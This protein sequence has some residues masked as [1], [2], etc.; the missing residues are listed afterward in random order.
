MTGRTGTVAQ[1]MQKQSKKALRK[2]QAAAALAGLVLVIAG[3]AALMPKGKGPDPKDL[4]EIEN[5]ITDALRAFDAKKYKEADDIC[6]KL[7]PKIKAVGTVEK[8]EFKEAVRKITAYHQSEIHPTA[9]AEGDAERAFSTWLPKVD[10]FLKTP[11]P[12]DKAEGIR[13]FDLGEP[14]HAKYPRYSRADEITKKLEELEKY[15]LD[16][17]GGD[18][19]TKVYQSIAA[20]IRKMLKDKMFGAAVERWKTGK[21]D[22]KITDAKIKGQID[23]QVAKVLEQAKLQLDKWTREA[24][25]KRDDLS[26]RAGGLKVL[27]EARARIKGLADLEKDLEERIK[28]YNEGKKFGG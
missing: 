2:F 23:D 20:E 7:E 5:L 22:P 28:G 13:L 15:K 8:E 25:Q 17:A 14:N 12:R 27:D 3:A 18:E 11:E 19:S 21:A 24:E 4:I 10:E 26:D 1:R 16:D 6:H 9:A